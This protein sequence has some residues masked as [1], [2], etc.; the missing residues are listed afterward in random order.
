MRAESLKLKWRTDLLRD[1]RRE[2]D[3]D[4]KRLNEKCPEARCYEPYDWCNL[5]DNICIRNTGNEDFDRECEWYN[6]FLEEEK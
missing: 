1:D 5:S 4:E 2:M 3:M 6:L